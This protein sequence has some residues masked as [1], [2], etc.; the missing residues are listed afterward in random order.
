MQRFGQVMASVAHRFARR[1][2]RAR[3]GAYVRGLLAGSSARTGGRRPSTR[4]GV[5]RWSPGARDHDARPR[6]PRRRTGRLVVGDCGRG[7]RAGTDLPRRAGRAR[8]PVGT[9]HPPR[10]RSEQPGRTPPPGRVFATPG[11]A[12]APDA[13]RNG[14]NRRSVG[15]GAHGD[16]STTPTSVA[17]DP[18][19]LPFRCGAPAATPLRELVRVAGARWPFEDR[20]RRARSYRCA[21]SRRETA[22]I[23]YWTTCSPAGGGSSRRA[24]RLVR[25][26]GGTGP[27][28]RSVRSSTAPGGVVAHGARHRGGHR[29]GH[30]GVGVPPRPASR[31]DA[32]VGSAPMSA[33][34]VPPAGCAAVSPARSGPS[35]TACAP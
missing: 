34:A 7:P 16:G 17:L 14:W 22:R 12:R 24:Q 35:V 11:R 31:S 27:G 26:R 3:A 25:D 33:G 5:A 23:R 13:G 15:S 32:S 1:E 21:G 18:T 29:R 8:D 28:G 20:T 10:R 6:A 19:G 4:R 30:R 9:G 2:P